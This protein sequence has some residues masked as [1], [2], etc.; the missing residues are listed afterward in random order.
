[1]GETPFWPWQATHV[2]AIAGGL[3]DGSDGAASA[4]EMAASRTIAVR[5][6]DFDLAGIAFDGWLVGQKTTASA[7]GVAAG[8][9]RRRSYFE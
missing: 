4:A 8:G 3:G 6:L 5:T 2:T 1:M 7:R 9:Q